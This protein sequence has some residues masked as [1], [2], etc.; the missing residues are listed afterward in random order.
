MLRGITAGHP[1]Q[2]GN[3]RTGFLL[4]AYYLELMGHSFPD[5]FAFDEAEVLSRQVSAGEL[6]DAS[7]IAVELRRLWTG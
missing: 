1:F 6:R 4:A 7:R 3:K 2:D 5:R